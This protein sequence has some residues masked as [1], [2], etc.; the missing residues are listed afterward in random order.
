M[1]IYFDEAGR[2]PLAWPLYIGLIVS[3]L[4][5]KELK[6][7]PLFRDS[8]KLSERQR[9][10]AFEQIEILI[11]EGKLVTCTASVEAEFID[12]YGVTKAIF[13][14]ICKGL[15][16]LFHALLGNKAKGKRSLEDLKTLLH[17]RETEHHEKVLLILDGKSDFWLWKALG[18]ET[19][20]IVHGDDHLAEI[21]IASLLAKVSR[22]HQMYELAKSHPHYSFEQH[23]GYGTKA[24]YQAIEQYGICPIHRKL[25]LKTYFP[26]WKIKK[27]Q[28]IPLLSS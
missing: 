21:S 7:F 24:H 20:T 8:K 26:D 18:I 5:R 27:W 23:K 28:E 3:K 25:F 14:A 4:S 19:K 22:D 2:G 6:A 9:E 10:T 17:T 1:E 15:Y 11:S 13:F 12:E 16:Q